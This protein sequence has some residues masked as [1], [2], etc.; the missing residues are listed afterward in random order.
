MCSLKDGPG[1]RGDLALARHPRLRVLVHFRNPVDLTCGSGKPLSDDLLYGFIDDNCASVSLPG[2]CQQ[3][4][5]EK[6]WQNCCRSSNGI[7]RRTD[8][9]NPVFLLPT[10]RLQ[11]KPSKSIK[12]HNP[13]TWVRFTVLSL[14]P[15]RSSRRLPRYDSL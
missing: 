8:F 11:R 14:V 1:P 13:P 7:F 2:P 6:S 9:T 5:H 12:T 4:I 3:Y 10:G 15:E